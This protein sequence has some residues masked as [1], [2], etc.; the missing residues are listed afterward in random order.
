VDHMRYVEGFAPPEAK[1][2]V[3]PHVGHEV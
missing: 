3:D 2:R 1:E